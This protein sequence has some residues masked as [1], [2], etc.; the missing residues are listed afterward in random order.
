MNLRAL[1]QLVAQGESEQLEFKRTTGQRSDAAK[2]VCAMLNGAGGVVLFGVTDAGA[3][4]GQQVTAGT[5]EDI[6]TELRRIEPP[7][8]PEIE[9]VKL[10]RGRA[11]AAVHVAGGGG[12][13][14]YDGRAYVRHGPTTRPM[15]RDRYERILLERMHAGERWENQSATD[16]RLEDLDDGEISR[17]I[18]EAVRRQRMA[19]PGSRDPI[20]ALRGL[21][22]VRNGHLVRAAAVLF[23]RR[24]HLLPRYTQCVLR[25]AR[26]RGRDR[27]EFVDNRQEIGHAFDLFQRA[28]RFLIDHLPVAGRIVPDLFERVDDPLYPTAALREALANA[29]CHRDYSI[30]GGAVSIGIYDDRLEIASTGVLPFGL[31]L[32]DLTRPHPS[33]PWNPLIAQAFYRRGIIEAWGRGTLKIVELTRRAG[34]APPE[35]ECALGEVIVRFR[36][37]RY[38]PP[39]RVGHDLSP[40]QRELLEA[41]ARRGPTHLAVVRQAIG[42]EAAERTVRENLAVLRHLGLV[43][44][45]GRGR[46]A[47]WK[48]KPVD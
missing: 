19:D 22:L 10:D 1:R 13:Y 4:Q 12:P 3:V 29:L 28:Q 23:G 26:F 44:S 6:V 34:L 16:T 46:G 41:L 2:T 48:L 33:R 37:T 11:V 7:A 45:S 14:T 20:E 25:M 38:T 8:F 18:D 30:G 15:P 9:T 40:L 17:T 36:P 42:L 32:E 43:E 24:E 27:T 5:L 31:T 35:F 47:R 21:G 39:T